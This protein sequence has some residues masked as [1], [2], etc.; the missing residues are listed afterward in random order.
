M[1]KKDALYYNAELV[2]LYDIL[3]SGRQDFDF[4][5]S[6]LPSPPADLLD[7]GCGTGTFTHELAKLGYKVSALDPSPE[8]ISFA[9]QKPGADNIKWHVGGIGSAFADQTFDIALMTGHAFQCLLADSEILELFA[10]VAQRLT[11]HGKFLFESRNPDARS[12]ERWRLEYADPP[13]LLPSGAKLKTSHNVISFED[14]IV[15]F[16]ENYEFDDD[17]PSR[18]SE[19]Q[20]RFASKQHIIDLANQSG[21]QPRNIWGNWDGASEGHE[22]IFEL[23]TI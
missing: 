4:Y 8:M 23:I 14:E 11:A 13:T 16:Q 17:R 19:S 9:R 21:L 20:L 5:L 10:I 18:V 1:T 22:M 6:K 3:N 2:P 7:I 12:W 15:T